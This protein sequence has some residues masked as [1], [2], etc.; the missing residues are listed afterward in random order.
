[1]E[2]DNALF[3]FSVKNVLSQIDS[4]SPP[5]PPSMFDHLQAC[6]FT[7]TSKRVW[8]RV[9][10]D[11]TITFIGLTELPI[12]Y[13]VRI[14]EFDDTSANIVWKELR[15]GDNPVKKFAEWAYANSI[16]REVPGQ[17][18]DLV[19]CDDKTVSFKLEVQP[20]DRDLI[21]STWGVKKRSRAP[22]ESQRNWFVGIISARAHGVDLRKFDGR[23]EEVQA[24]IMGDDHFGPIMS[25]IIKEVE[26][27]N[28]TH[29]STS[30][31]K[32]RHRSVAVAELLK[33]WFYPRAVVRHLTI[34]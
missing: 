14:S 10:E 15:E 5:S 16:A 28:L 23:S 20:T 7:K 3:D 31:T 32:G 12:D 9:S 25:S 19:G 8:K 6:G 26:E 24:G 22:E 1:M 33:K 13:S 18:V 17:I 30:C 2:K 34:N 21:I 27:H 11:H 4:D 29:I